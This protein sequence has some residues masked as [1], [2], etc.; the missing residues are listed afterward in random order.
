MR[1]SRILLAV[2]IPALAA[3]GGGGGGGGGGGAAPAVGGPIEG[4]PAAT[5]EAFERGRIL[6]KKRF[7][8]SEGL[9]TLYNASSCDS[10]HSTPVTG[11]SAPNYRNF[12]M[13]ATWS[14]NPTFQQPAIGPDGLPLPSFVL[15]SY[16]ALDGPRAV[17]PDEVPPFF[18]V[19]VTQRNAP[20]TFGVGLFEFVS[21]AEIL[22]RSDPDD[23]VPAGGD[24]ISGRVNQTSVNGMLAIGRFGY[25]AQA[26]NIEAFIRGAA[27][28]QMGLTSN[29][30]EG[31]G[32]IVT[33][34]DGCFRPLLQVSAIQDQPITD[35]D[36]VGDPEIS[37]QIMSDLVAFSRFLAP[38]E[39][40]PF[41]AAALRGEQLFESLGCAKCHVPELQSTMGP[42]RAYTDLLLHDMGPDLA[43]GIS[44][45]IPEPSNLPGDLPNTTREFRT[46]PLWGVSMSAPYLHDGRADTLHAAIVAHGGEAESIRMAYEALTQEDKDDLIAFLEAL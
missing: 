7:T 46:Q 10:C 17:I 16:A 6:M 36:G 22:S 27:F 30:V 41:N 34:A 38:P 5:L 26:N 37:A 32:A 25:K 11:G 21:D 2:I 13:V 39:P 4:L 1:V 28:N 33:T 9:G 40:K 45:G 18:N 14:V 23:L 24:G 31:N 12:Y 35:N 3:C 8:P 42:L 44:L 20:P 15:P 29:P 43:D 19:E